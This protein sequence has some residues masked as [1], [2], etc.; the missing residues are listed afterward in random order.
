MQA[1]KKWIFSFRYTRRGTTSLW[2][3]GKGDC[4]E[5]PP[6]DSWRSP[7][8][9]LEEQTEKLEWIYVSVEKTIDTEDDIEDWREES[10]DEAEESADAEFQRRHPEAK[11]V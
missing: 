5:D 1:K 8:A 9:W 6:D 3:R 2:D 4:R 7:G 11:L 10:L